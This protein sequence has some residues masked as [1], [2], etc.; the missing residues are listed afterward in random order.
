LCL[1]MT[2]FSSIRIA[3]TLDVKGEDYFAFAAVVQNAQRGG[4]ER[5]AILFMNTPASSS[6]RKSGTLS[7]DHYS[8]HYLFEG[9]CHRRGF[10]IHNTEE[11][12]RLR[13]PGWI[14]L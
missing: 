10:S 6:P 7:C 11:H 4:I 8:W 14:G 9:G 13:P 12:L 5:P 1:I 2:R 3:H